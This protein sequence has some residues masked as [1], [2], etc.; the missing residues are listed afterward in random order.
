MQDAT[1]P[2]KGYGEE[3][4]YSS[5]FMEYKRF[6]KVC[7][8][9]RGNAKVFQANT[10]FLGGKCK[11]FASK[12][13]VCQGNLKVLRVK[14]AVFFGGV[15]KF[16]QVN[17]AFLGGTQKFLQVNAMLFCWKGQKFCQQMQS[18]STECGSKC[19]QMQ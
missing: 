4:I 7:N 19:E 5:A 3:K 12:H 16:W 18:F 13:K 14:A 6:S 11:S 10:V 15:Q 9:S 1:E 17:A 8:V 2:L